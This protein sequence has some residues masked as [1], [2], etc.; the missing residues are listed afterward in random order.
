MFTCTGIL[1]AALVLGQIGLPFCD[2]GLG[3][4]T[5]QQRGSE[6]I[7]VF[8][9]QRLR[10]IGK[11]EYQGAHQGIAFLRHTLCTSFYIGAQR[12]TLLQTCC[13]NT[14][15]LLTIVPRLGI[16]HIA[17][18]THQWQIDA[19][20]YPTQHTL[21]IVLIVILVAGTEESTGIIRPPGHAS[22][23]YAQTCHYLTTEGL[24]VVTHITAP[25]SRAVTLDTGESA[26][27]EYHR[28]TTC[29]YQSF[30]HGL[31]DQQGIDVTHLFPTPPAILDATAHKVIILRLSSILPP[32]IYTQRQQTLAE[33]LPIRCGSLRI[34]EV[35]PVGTGD[36]VVVTYH[37][38]SYLRVLVYLRPYA[39]HQADI[40]L[41]QR[42]GQRLGV[43]I[44]RFV[45][46]HRVP[47]VFAPVLPVLHNHADGHLLFLK[48]TG[49]LQDFIRAMETLTTVDVS[50]C[51]T[52]H[53]WTFACQFTIGG[54]DFV[55]GT[56][57]HS[58]VDS[59]S[60]RRTEHG[61]VLDFVVI[62]HGLV[63]LRQFCCYRMV[64]FLQTN[65]LR[66]RRR[67]PHILHLDD[68][69]SVDTQ[70]MTTRH[71]LS[72]IQQQTIV[73]GL[74]NIN[75]SLEDMAFTHLPTVTLGG[76]HVNHIASP[77]TLTL[78]QSD[79]LFAWIKLRQSVVIPQDAI[80]L[81]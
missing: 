24:P 50:Q 15:G 14:L 8:L 28:F 1:P 75:S 29:L 58:I 67:Q 30:I 64:S 46:T 34:E 44:M 81:A 31:V 79:K 22:S 39:E 69:L 70:M 18:H 21:N 17:M 33:V 54:D 72:Y 40:H 12:L 20:L 61:L 4:R 7:L 73:T 38:T 78:L 74:S 45:E 43:R 76:R 53:L 62:Q 63:V 59:S 52:G 5:D 32:G 27:S 11:V 56:D 65:N 26:A 25:Q 10:V 77:C 47:T 36:V 68:W 80:A 48:A 55:G 71:L 9:F 16:A 51:P 60:D 13:K 41:V 66:S 3:N 19:G 49:R 57:E 2:T 6:H 35:Y 23:L 37:L 42:I